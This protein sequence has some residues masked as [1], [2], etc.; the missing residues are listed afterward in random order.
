LRKQRE[1]ID[2]REIETTVTVELSDLAVGSIESKDAL[3]PLNLRGAFTCDPGRRRAVVMIE[4]Q[5]R[6]RAEGGAGPP[7]KERRAVRT[8]SAAK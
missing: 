6:G 7:M 4:Q 1:Q 8:I 5:L 3:Q 2:R